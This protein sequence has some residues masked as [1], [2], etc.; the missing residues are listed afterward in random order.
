MESESEIASTFSTLNV[1]AVE[2]IP[3]FSSTTKESDKPMEEITQTPS[4]T[5]EN[6]GNGKKVQ[7]QIAFS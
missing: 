5:P 3:S 2:F 4:E 7:V 1:N 6:N